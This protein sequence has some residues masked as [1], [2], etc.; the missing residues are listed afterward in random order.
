MSGNRHGELY[1]D[2][3][4]TTEGHPPVPYL[5]RAQWGADESLRLATAGREIWPARF[6]PVQTITVH[7][8]AIEVGPDATRGVRDIYRLHAVDNGWGDIGYHLLVDA[9]G[10]VYEG[11]HCG[12][13]PAPILVAHPPLPGRAHAVTAG[14]V[15]GRNPGNIGV[16]MLGDFSSGVPGSRAQ[17]SLVRLLAALCRI[18]GIRPAAAVRYTNPLTGES[19]SVSGLTRH[20]DWMRTD[21]PGAAFAGRFGALVRERVAERLGFPPQ[22]RPAPATERM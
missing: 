11:R 22:E 12:T 18:V 19:A 16:C 20:R 4:C 21:C 17:E 13:A 10:V 6:F 2:A 5:T 15:R 1:R 3:G 9:A 8:S 7:H 14:H